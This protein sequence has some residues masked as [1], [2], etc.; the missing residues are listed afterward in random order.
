MMFSPVNDN[1]EVSSATGRS[2]REGVKGMSRESAAYVGTDG[3]PDTSTD[4]TA[5][6]TAV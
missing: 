6:T 1:D 5:F 4:P 2:R 3:F